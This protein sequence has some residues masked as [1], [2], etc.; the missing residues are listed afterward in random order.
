MI[1]VNLYIEDDQSTNNNETT[2]LIHSQQLRPPSTSSN[3]SQNKKLQI[4]LID[5]QGYFQIGK[6]TENCQT[7]VLTKEAREKNLN[8]K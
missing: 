4:N 1:N 3:S 7:Y 5:E 2:T 6:Q 8:K